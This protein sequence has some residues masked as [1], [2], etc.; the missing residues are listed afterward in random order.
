MGLHTILGKNTAKVK[1]HVF[2]ISFFYRVNDT[3]VS[4]ASFST[5]MG[6]AAIITGEMIVIFQNLNFAWLQSKGS[7]PHKTTLRPNRSIIQKLT[8]SK[9]QAAEHSVSFI[10]FI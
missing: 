4:L 10:V 1:G 2:C 3:G 9:A 5:N 6:V 8:I 7:L